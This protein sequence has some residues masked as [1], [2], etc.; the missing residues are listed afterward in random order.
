MLHD[1]VDGD[2]VLALRPRDD[3]VRV[4]LARGDEGVEHGLD[5]RGVLG[6]DAVD[7][8]AAVHGVPLQAPRQAKIVVGVHEYFHVAQFPHL[9]HGQHQDALHD[10]HVRGLDRHGLVLLARVRDE[11][12]GPRDDDVRVPL[13]RGDEGVEHGLDERGV[14]GDDAVDASAA[15][16]GVPLQAPRQAKIV[17]GVH[18]YFHVAQF[19]HLRHGQHQDA[20]H[21]DHVRG[22]DRH[23]LVLLARVRDE[24]VDGHLHLV[25]QRQVPKRL[26]QRR[27]VDGVWVV[28]VVAADVVVLLLGQT[29]VERVLRDEH[30]ALLL[31]VV[32]DQVAH[33]GLPG[34]GAPRDSDEE[35]LLA[36]VA[37]HALVE[38]GRERVQICAAPP[39]FPDAAVTLQHGAQD[40]V[41]VGVEQRPGRSRGRGGYYLR[42]RVTHS[43]KGR[44]AQRRRWS[45]A[46]H[47]SPSRQARAR[48]GSSLAPSSTSLAAVRTALHK[49][50]SSQV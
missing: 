1:E 49:Q 3:D 47:V 15:V 35:G 18:E 16:H 38:D 26:H 24:V 29:P 34:C 42:R 11:V 31:Q 13:A 37:L 19:P 43:S 7:A 10:D 41:A 23:G 21:D 8:S 25:P 36:A 20:L 17:V 33:G 4:P 12:V 5:E 50:D 30:H 14:L 9:R 27:D 6:D 39:P 48:A 45:G 32:H 2:V 22:L 28:E 44:L 40:G 46:R